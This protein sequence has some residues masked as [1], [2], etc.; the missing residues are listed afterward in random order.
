MPAHGVRP[1]PS[2]GSGNAC[3]WRVSGHGNGAMTR[4]QLW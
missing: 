4:L 2:I 1:I 3:E